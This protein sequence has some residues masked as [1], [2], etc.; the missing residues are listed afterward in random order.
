MEK[1]HRK[2]GG[3]EPEQRV[4]SK[5]LPKLQNRYARRSREA[6]SQML[7]EVCEDYG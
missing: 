7:D 4:E 3:N 2:I 6:K 1:R 5:W